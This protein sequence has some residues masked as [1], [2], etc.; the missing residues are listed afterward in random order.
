MKPKHWAAFILVGLIWSSSFMWIKIALNEVSPVT[1]VAFR[2]GL[3]FL[4]GAIVVAIQKVKL[5]RDFK[6][7]KPF[8]V[9]GITNFALP[10]FLISWGEQ[11]VDS[12]VAS[13]I[14]S[15]VPLFT[16]VLAHFLLNDDKMNLSKVLG[17]LIGFMG[18]VILLSKNIGNSSGNLLGEG[19]IVLASLC[20]AGSAVYIRKTTQ[21][22]PR[23]LRSTG[24]M[25]F[26]AIIMWSTV[27]ITEGQLPIPMFKMTWVALLFL[28]IVGSG[29]AF[30]L[31]F[32]LIHE[33]G[34][35][36]T[37]M[38]TYIFPLGGIILGVIVL[39]EQITWQLITGGILIIASLA[40]ANMN[41]IDS[42]EIKK[43]KEQADM[44]LLENEK[45]AN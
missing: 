1:L 30:I 35:T 5:P 27:F 25:F 23:I 3:G 7:W 32:Y 29:F 43:L 44:K 18:V 33:I 20:Y 13:I 10:F 39:H 36:R 8:I 9:I 45:C 6:E 16:I 4:F 40:A 42:S 37:T 21:N 14:D 19:A 17:L 31:V 11:T 22:T 38:V 28:G 2:I 15:T 24:P 12:S 26:A 41:S 34:P